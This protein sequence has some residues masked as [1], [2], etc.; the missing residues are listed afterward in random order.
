MIV[1]VSVGFDDFT[2]LSLT[3]IERNKLYDCFLLMSHDA[4]LDIRLRSGSSD[5]LWGLLT[6]TSTIEV[7]FFIPLSTV[8]VLISSRLVWRSGCR[9]LVRK[10]RF[11]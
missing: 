9:K 1:P 4:M 11:E 10:W 2:L 6:G 3:T 5:G 8:N 7:P